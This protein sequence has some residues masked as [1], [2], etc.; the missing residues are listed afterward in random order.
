MSMQM[1]E[2]AITSVNEKLILTFADFFHLIYPLSFLLV[3]GRMLSGRR[4]RAVILPIIVASVVASAAV[5]P[6]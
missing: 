3:S 5:A 2:K 1:T 6:L 4:G